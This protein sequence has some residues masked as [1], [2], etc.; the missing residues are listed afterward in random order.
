MF[1]FTANCRIVSKYLIFLALGGVC[2]YFLLKEDELEFNSRNQHISS[3]PMTIQ[4]QIPVEQ[5]GLVIG[6]GGDNI[7]VRFSIS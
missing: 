4:V 5:V 2:A 6:R 1:Y 3:R 7:K